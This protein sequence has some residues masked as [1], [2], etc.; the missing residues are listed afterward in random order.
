MKINIFEGARRIT[1]IVAVLWIAGVAAITFSQSDPYIIATFTTSTSTSR[2]VRIDTTCPNDTDSRL[3]LDQLRALARFHLDAVKTKKGTEAHISLCFL[4]EVPKF[5]VTSP[6][7]KKFGVNAPDGATEQQAIRYAQGKQKKSTFDLATAKP[8]YPSTKHP[9]PHEYTGPVIPFSEEEK[10]EFQ[11][12]LQKEWDAAAMGW[13]VEPYIAHVQKTFVL[14]QEDED[15][16]DG[17]WWTKRWEQVREG[18]LWLVG[19]LAFL[20]GF[21]RATGW[22]VRGFMGIPKGQDRRLSEG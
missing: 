19:G 11:A 9:A 10:F 4:G 22:I 6:D 5:F 12:R 1:K 7:G 17:Q 15:W 3:L 2:F 8:V 20:W 21:T 14:S 18:A 13:S 16:I